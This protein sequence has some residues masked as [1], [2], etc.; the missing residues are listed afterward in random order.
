MERVHF[1]ITGTKLL[2]NSLLYSKYEA[3]NPLIC[4]WSP[5][6]GSVRAKCIGEESR[7][8]EQTERTDRVEQGSEEGSTRGSIGK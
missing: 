6:R 3:L 4:F 1:F 8:R 7:A 5:L 2:S